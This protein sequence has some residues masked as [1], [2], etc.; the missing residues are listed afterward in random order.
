LSAPPRL[1]RQPSIAST[2]PSKFESA[3]EKREPLLWVR[4][5]SLKFSPGHASGLVQT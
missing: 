4:L 3:R 1:V 5:L 2:M